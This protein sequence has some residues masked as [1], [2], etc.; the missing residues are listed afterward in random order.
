MPSKERL[1]DTYH[2]GDAR[3]IPTLFPQSEFVDATITSPP[4]WNLKDYGSKAQVGFGQDY[5][6]YLGDLGRIFRATYAITKKSGSLWVVA[7][8]IKWGGELKLFPFDLA[9]RL[10]KIGWVLQD[11]IIWHKDKTLPWSHRGKLRNIFEYILFFSKGPR[12]KYYLSRVRETEGLKEWWVRYPERYSPQGKAPTR[13]WSIP[14]P[15]QGS[16]GEN[17]VK[18]FCPFPPEIVRR[19]VLLT[20]QKGDVVFDPFAGSGVVLAQSKALMRRYVGLD[21]RRSYREMFLGRVLPSVLAMESGK[22]ECHLVKERKRKTH[23]GLIWRL[24]KTKYP[25]ELLRL[26]EKTHGDL[27]VRGMLA[28]AEGRNGVHVV[29]ALAAGKK[30]PRNVTSN[31]KLLTN[32]PPLSK[33]GLKVRVSTLPL[34]GNPIGALKNRGIGKT[35]KLSLYSNGRTFV[36]AGQLTVAEFIESLKNGTAD[37][38]EK[39]QHRRR[40]AAP[41]IAS[42]INVSVIKVLTNPNG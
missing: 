16:W 10:K 33:Y 34:N 14:I 40:R 17:W 3:T 7:D 4:Y 15:R 9:A 24:R 19:I 38:L 41:P 32:K 21:L 23:A 12:F 2:I 25:R 39:G 31:I 35:K 13:T 11:V 26:Y 5:Q 8:T 18:H 1:L 28:L 42:D 6:K 20:T 36:A 37:V 30:R 22:S 27:G 29:L